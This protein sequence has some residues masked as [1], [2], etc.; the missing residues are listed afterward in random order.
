[1]VRGTRVRRERG[2]LLTDPAEARW[3]R[4]DMASSRRCAPRSAAGRAPVGE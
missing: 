1:M 3:N 2:G 4:D